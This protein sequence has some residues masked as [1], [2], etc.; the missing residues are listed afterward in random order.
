MAHDLHALLGPDGVATTRE[1]TR[2][3]DRHSVSAWVAS[4][5][6]LRPYP[7]VVTLP[8]AFAEWHTQVV[9]AVLATGG[10][11]SHTSAL[12][13]WRRASRDGAVH[14]SVPASRRALRRRGL[15]VHR[16]T[17]V[18]VDRLGGLPVTPLPRSLVD[19]WGW[20]HSARGSAELVETARRAVL[21][22]LRDRQVDLP[23][24]RFELGRQPALAG[25]RG[26]VELAELVAQGCESE[27]EI[28]GVQHVLRGPGMPV[29]Q[30]QYRVSLPFG[31]VRLDA[32]VPE[33][34]VAVEMDGAAFHGSAEARERDIRRDAALAARGWVVLRFSYRRLRQEPEAC[35]REILAVCRARAALLLR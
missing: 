7:G 11:L 29:F 33:L 32:A 12:A 9:A 4:G 31:T 19:A 25:R 17:E 26:L 3:V 14:V 23:A 18:P 22:S 1:L 34:K 24:L 5:R 35:R 20:A 21:E 16:A 27:L 30:Q 10:T 15:V 8:G 28:W 13:L 6:L 2:R